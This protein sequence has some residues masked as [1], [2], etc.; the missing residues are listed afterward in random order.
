MC[1]YVLRRGKVIYA[2]LYLF[3]GTV[4]VQ[5]I[6]YAYTYGDKKIINSLEVKDDE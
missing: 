4:D 1:G 2:F 3:P 6:F 5:F